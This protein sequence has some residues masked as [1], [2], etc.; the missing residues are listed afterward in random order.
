[1]SIKP[2]D[3]STN[4][5]ARASLV[6]ACRSSSPRWAFTLLVLASVAA[7]AQRPATENV[8]AF[9]SS[10]SA[11]TSLVDKGL[12]DLSAAEL[13]RRLLDETVA[14]VATRRGPK[15]SL[16]D[17]TNADVARGVLTPGFALISGYAKQLTALTGDQ[18]IAPL[19]SATDTLQKSFDS[20]L[21][22]LQHSSKLKVD[23]S[24]VS[25]AKQGSS[26]LSA[27]V[28]VAVEQKIARD[29]AAA[30]ELADPAVRQI[31][32]LIKA[33]VGESP[34]RGLRLALTS[35]A[36][37]SNEQS[38]V[39]L[40]LYAQDNR[41]STGQLADRYKAEAVRRDGRISDVYLADILTAID[42]M[43]SAHSA[44][45][46]PTEVSTR[47]AIEEFATSVSE[48]EA[49]YQRLHGLGN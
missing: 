4:R 45:R 46:R 7:C 17:P 28:E 41:M 5:G 1:M 2:G 6:L 26:V 30:V 42:R 40:G 37:G 36:I 19:T 38:R 31:G 8:A 33:V 22:T 27:I 11:T 39:L 23:G 21:D 32:T 3:P 12:L 20:A 44:L 35:V 47:Q 18:S 34:G 49:S 13:D 10:L 48:L 15:L 25:G 14:Y 43:I 9:A 24:L 16:T 29:V